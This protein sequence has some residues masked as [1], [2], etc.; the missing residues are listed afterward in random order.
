LDRR[1]YT[2]AGDSVVSALALTR[3]LGGHCAFFWFY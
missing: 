3:T 2:H 1:N